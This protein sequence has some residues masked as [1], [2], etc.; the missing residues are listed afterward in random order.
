MTKQKIVN[1]I[2]ENLPSYNTEKVLDVKLIKGKPITVEHYVE[3]LSCISSRYY[4][5]F[6]H[7]QS[8]LRYETQIYKNYYACSCIK[9]V[10]QNVKNIKVW[11]LERCL[12]TLLNFKSETIHYKEKQ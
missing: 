2:L 12:N 8:C 4:S 7:R 9:R 5:Y 11:Q 6:Y 10:L 1:Q 3:I